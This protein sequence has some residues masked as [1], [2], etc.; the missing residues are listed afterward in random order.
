MSKRHVFSVVAMLE[1]LTSDL[2]AEFPESAQGFL[3]TQEHLR[4]AY[5]ERGVGVFYTELPALCKHL[6]RCLD[7]GQFSRGDEH[8]AFLAPTSP[9]NLLPVIWG[10]LWEKIFC[11]S[12]GRLLLENGEQIVSV[13]RLLRQAL[14][15]WKKIDVECPDDA[16]QDTILSFVRT[17]A[18]LPLPS[19][20]WCSD[21]P[22]DPNRSGH[23][24]N[25]ADLLG[26]EGEIGGLSRQHLG[27]TMD[28][29]AAYVCSDLG[30]YEPQ[31]NRFHHGPGAVA[32]PREGRSKYSFWN[33]DARLDAVFPIS[34]CG[35]SSCEWWVD[36]VVRGESSEVGLIGN[37][38]LPSRMVAVRKTY[39]GPRLIA[40]EP[41]ERQWCQQNI[42][43]FLRRRVS[44]CWIGS[45]ILFQDQ[46]QNQRLCVQ[47]SQDGSLATIDLSDASDRVTPS[48]VGAA[49]RTNVSLLR[50][51]MATRT[52]SVELP[53]GL[54]T[55]RLRKFS[56]MGSAC[57]F[58]VESLV[59]L[60]VALA[61]Q[62]VKS[63]GG[64]RVN[65]GSLLALQGKTSVFGDDIIVPSDCYRA[66]VG[67]LEALCFKVNR[68]KSFSG[69]YFRESCGVDAWMGEVVTPVYWRKAQV[70]SV[71]DIVSLSETHEALHRAG[72][73]N[74]AGLAHAAICG[75]LSPRSESSTSLGVYTP[76][77]TVFSP[78][79]EECQKDIPHD[80]VSHQYRWNR[81]LQRVEVRVRRV[82]VTTKRVMTTGHAALLQYFTESCGAP[83]PKG[84]LATTLRTHTK[85]VWGWV[86]P[87]QQFGPE[88]GRSAEII[89]LIR[90]T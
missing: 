24:S 14:C 21:R 34:S 51:L 79:R 70:A 47:G 35:F 84:E 58:P 85:I 82:K 65:R 90:C 39:K 56:T 59:F 89:G 69:R 37:E 71:E 49:F 83:F 44:R 17:D 68:T 4:A 41:V 15:L 54:G 9:T 80:L 66:T 12:S 32:V 31:E 10:E 46:S 53:D 74:L 62:H 50:A 52:R 64:R 5:T 19:R 38:D 8:Q 16:R 61:V 60:L 55:R 40:C 88:L 72:L 29:I 20:E 42:W 86:C 11:V 87:Y 36:S 77:L 43:H 30:A 23:V 6:D 13:V 28:A 7:E 26:S 81:T 63:H 67:L 57:T 33:W 27:R 48:V 1:A 25:F 2:V 78:H 45:F 22:Y 18:S 76:S 3:R 75:N 73:R